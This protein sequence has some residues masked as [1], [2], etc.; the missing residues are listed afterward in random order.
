MMARMFRF[1]LLAAVLFVIVLP[2][3]AV[4]LRRGPLAT[5]TPVD[6][7]HLAMARWM[8]RQLSD[9]LVRVSIPTDQRRLAE[10]LLGEF[11]GDRDHQRKEL[12]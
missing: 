3:A 6:R 4:L 10:G 1:F 11:Y 9:D 8:E 2:L 12:P 7:N 5:T